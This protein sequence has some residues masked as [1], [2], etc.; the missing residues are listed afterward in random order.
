MSPTKEWNELKSST[1]ET[2][3]DSKGELLP[4]FCPQ[5]PGI[6]R[7]DANPS[8]FDFFAGAQLATRPSPDLGPGVGAQVASRQSLILRSYACSVFVASSVCANWNG[9]K[10]LTVAALSDHTG[11]ATDASILVPALL[12]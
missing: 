11:P 1:D 7:R 9:T 2:R 6:C 5:P 3:C 4:V 8:C 10:H 12:K